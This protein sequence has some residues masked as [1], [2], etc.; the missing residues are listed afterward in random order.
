[1]KKVVLI[2]IAA[3]FSVNIFA[4]SEPKVGLNI[5]DKA[6]N[7]SF[8]DPNGKIISLDDLKGQ[9]VLIDFWASWCRPCRIENPNLVK[10]Y[11]QFKYAEFENA[12]GFTIYSYSLDKSKDAWQR[13][14]MQDGLNW[15]NHVSDLAGWGAK[16][17]Q[18]YN[19]R[20]IPQAYLINGDGV[21][22]GKGNNVRGG[23]LTKLLYNLKK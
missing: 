9:M 12:K 11:K 2:A 6:P 14:I 4:Q 7:L 3:L 16:G 10:T 21:I 1:M 23:N 17:A 19:V 13:A 20:F 5:G 15:P 22:V 18:T 8:E